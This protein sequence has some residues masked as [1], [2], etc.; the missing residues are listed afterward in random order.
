MGWD[1]DGNGN[2]DALT[3]GRLVLGYLFGLTGEA[4][5]KN[6]L[7]PDATR[8]EADQIIAYLESIRDQLDV[9]GNDRIDA[10]TDGVLYLRDLFGFRGEDLTR[11]AVGAGA[12]R[13]NAEQ[14][15]AYLE[16]IGN[17]TSIDEAEIRTVEENN[18][19]DLEMA[20]ERASDLDRY[21]EEELAQTQEWA[22]GL[23]RDA[24]IPENLTTELGVEKVRP[25]EDSPNT[26][27]LEFSGDA[28]AREIATVL[29]SLSGVEFAYPLV[30]IEAVPDYIPNDPLFANQWHLRNT[31]QTGG[32]PGVDANLS[33]AWNIEVPGNS[34]LT[35]RGR[36]VVIGIVDDGLEFT[37]PDIANRYRNDLS[38]DFNDNDG[39]PSPTSERESHG[40]AVAGIA[41]ADGDNGIGI[42]GAAPQAF[43]TGL[44]LLGSRFTDE[45]VADA[46]SWQ[47]QQIDIY[48]NSWSP[49]ATLDL[50]GPDRLLLRTLQNGVARGRRGRGNIYVF[51]AGNNRQPSLINPFGDDNVNYNGYANSPYTIAVGA[52]D[53]NGR[54]A[55]YSEPG[56]ALLI[57]APSSNSTVGITTTGLVGRGSVE[58]DYRD[59]F[60]GTSA[61][62]PLVAGVVALMLEVNPEL[63]WRDVQH[64]LVETAAINDQDNSDWVINGAGFHVNHLYGFGAIDAEAAV[65]MAID[66]TPVDPELII[67]EEFTSSGSLAIPDDDPGGIETTV[68]FDSDIKVEWAEVVFQATHSERGELEVVL[69]SPDGTESILAEER[70]DFRANYDWTF[71][72]S[73]HWGESSLG[74]WTLRVSDSITGETGTLDF[75]ELRLMGTVNE[76]ADDAPNQPPIALNDVATTA[77]S[78]SVNVPVL[79][80]DFDADD[81]EISLTAVETPN[82]GT[83]SIEEN[84]L[85]YTPTANFTGTDSFTYRISDGNGG[86]DSATV[87]VTVEPDNLAPLAL[88]DVATTQVNSAIEISVLAN[89]FDLDGDRLSVTGVGTPINGS[90]AIEDNIV[91]YTPIAD[92]INTDSFTYTISDGQEIDSA[93]VTVTV[94]LPSLGSIAGVKFF[95]ANENGIQDDGE[96]G[97][98]GWT[99]FLD[100]NNDGILDDNEQSAVTDIDGGYLFN[101]LESETYN[102]REL[103]Q[104]EFVQTTVDPTIFLGPGEEFA[105]V[106]FGNISFGT[107]SG[108]KF[109]DTNFNGVRDAGEETLSGWTIF[110]DS[111][112]D[113]IL[114]EDEASAVTDVDGSYQFSDLSAGMYNV[115]E[116]QQPG[117]ESTTVNPVIIDL[118]ADEDRTGV[119]FGNLNVSTVT[120]TPGVPDTFFLTTNI[121]FIEGFIDGEDSLALLDRLTFGQLQITQGTGINSENTEIRLASSNQLIAIIVGVQASAITVEDLVAEA[122]N[123]IIG[124]DNVSND[125]DRERLDGS[126]GNDILIG[127]RGAD[128]LSGGA[129]ADQFVYNSL[130][131][132]GADP[133]ALTEGGDNILDFTPTEDTI[134]LN[135]EVAPGSPGRPVSIDDVVINLGFI[136]NGVVIIGLN[137][138]NTDPDFLTDRFVISLSGLDTTTTEADI[139]DSIQF[140]PL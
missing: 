136:E 111:N 31:G 124:D 131:D 120:G 67:T 46:L 70:G 89:D 39:D 129:G 35:V 32:T 63:S 82:N 75:A 30:P 90:V 53:H 135:F 3:D 79:N 115:R 50:R 1:V 96:Q 104:A 98:A 95:D 10:L 6:S 101:N 40:T 7:A 41:A 14:I 5:I 87:S 11:G 107:I 23:D 94:E 16:S 26:F 88:D 86:T 99:I 100:S 103:Q 105:G 126:D 18:A 61:A 139:L 138:P 110:L 37:H 134:R 84:Q 93:T 47:N 73:R 13:A 64:I 15:V 38:S 121:K 62:A 102:V 114:D 59:D 55:P 28:E 127:N 76:V 2:L 8:T 69:I 44:R 43:I 25:V 24:E 27:I 137:T 42:T 78:S 97:L 21:D 48:Q 92:L 80:N 118:A 85:L 74:E 56:A 54:H 60:A 68:T 12:V 20:A 33:A 36:G 19:L 17:P 4:L 122:I 123:V 49:T 106:N 108:V 117:F 57:S 91:V 9:D 81:D 71:T 66:W 116:I 29:Q 132:S 133:D 34:A 45:Q 65:R 119:N 128:I 109:K 77:E 130:A 22:I 51:S 52:I 125:G 83:V 58:N 113:G 140:G 112:N 72:S